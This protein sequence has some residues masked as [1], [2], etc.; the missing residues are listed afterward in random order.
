MEATDRTTIDSEQAARIAELE[1]LVAAQAALIEQ[2]RREIA[3]LKKNSSNSSKPPSSDL[4]KPPKPKPKKRGRRKR[5]GSTHRRERTPF[6][7]EEVD[8]VVHH[9]RP[10]DPLRYEKLEEPRVFQ[11]V[12]FEPARRR[13][14]VVEHRFTRYR[15]R[16]SGRVRTTPTPESLRGPIRGGLFDAAM[17]AFVTA[18]RVELGGSFRALQRHLADTWRLKVS[19]GYLKKAVFAVT[20]ALD[21]AYEQIRGAVR[22]SPAVFVDETGHKENGRR[23]WTWVFGSDAATLFRLAESRSHRELLEVLGPGYRGVI[24]CDCYSAYA[25]YAAKAPGALRQHCLAHLIRDVRALEVSTDPDVVLWS[26]AVQRQFG[27]LFRA[28]WKGWHKAVRRARDTI[29]ATCRRWVSAVPE[30]ATLRSR[31]DQEAESFF[32][33][34]EQ[35]PEDPVKLE[36]TNNRAERSLRPLVMFRRITQGTRCEAGR[37]WWE[38]VWSVRETLATQG[39]NFFGYVLEALN[40]KGAGLTPPSVLAAAG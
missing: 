22:Q 12:V 33:F 34:L 23:L 20:P 32:R 27:L 25:C 19:A 21:P 14:L 8:R 30:A 1:A 31:I 29:L 9:D 39:R 6:L 28:W 16:K 40:A 24:H 11:H 17:K 5:G 15:H 26:K 3:S 13:I 7:P 10:R 2:L 18:L 37:R 4:V 36:P 38:R 35:P